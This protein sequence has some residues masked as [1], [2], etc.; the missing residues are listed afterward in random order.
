MANKDFWE[1]QNKEIADPEAPELSD[2]YAFQQA[3]IKASIEDKINCKFFKELPI[4]NEIDEEAIKHAKAMGLT[5]PEFLAGK[6]SNELVQKMNYMKS[7][8]RTNLLLKKWSQDNYF[9]KQDKVCKIPED[10]VD[11]IDR[12][13]VDDLT[14]EQFIET[15]EIGHKPCIIHGIAD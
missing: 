14:T 10:F 4:E 15:Y 2:Q 8:H 1:K 11:N 5:E 9:Y 7:K 3:Y 6:M 12:I 13:H